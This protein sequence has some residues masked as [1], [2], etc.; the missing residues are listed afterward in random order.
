L[1]KISQSYSQKY[2]VTFFMVHCVVMSFPFRRQNVFTLSEIAT[3]TFYATSLTKHNSR[4][5]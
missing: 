3:A 1:V 5:K 4:K 2:N